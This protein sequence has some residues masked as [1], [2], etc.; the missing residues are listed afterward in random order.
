VIG[1]LRRDCLDHVIEL[2]AIQRL[3]DGLQ[4]CQGSGRCW[5][6]C[7][8]K[9]PASRAAFRSAGRQS[10]APQIKPASSQRRVNSAYAT[11]LSSTSQPNRAL[12]MSSAIRSVLAL[13]M[14]HGAER[15]HRVCPDYLPQSLTRAHPPCVE[16]SPRRRS[17]S[18]GGE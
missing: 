10:N 9:H 18:A 7:S 2:W 3:L 17:K 15:G 6:S 5:I 1:T 11:S 4:S 8:L 13:H 16:C 14:S 12:S